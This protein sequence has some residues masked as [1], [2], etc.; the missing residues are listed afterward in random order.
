[1]RRQLYRIAAVLADDRGVLLAATCARCDGVETN[2]VCPVCRLEF[3]AICWHAHAGSD[4]RCT[5]DAIARAVAD[6]RASWD[7][8][9]AQLR[10]RDQIRRGKLLSALAE[11][12]RI[13]LQ[14]IGPSD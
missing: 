2:S 5:G 10:A 9:N 3:C 7:T 11:D 6:A 4:T 1:M 12:G 8:F 13:E 14:P